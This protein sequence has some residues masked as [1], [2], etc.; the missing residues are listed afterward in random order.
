MASGV[1]KH[2]LLAGY[3]VI[4]LEKP[5][6]SCVRRCVCFA[7]AIYEERVTVEGVTAILVSTVEEAVA[8]TGNLI[9]PLLIDPEAAHLS[10]LA[11]SAVVDGRMLK[12]RSKKNLGAA[13]AVIGLGPGFVVS[14][15]CHAAIET[16]RGTNLGRVLYAGSPQAY[17]GVPA[18]VEGHTGKR[19]VRAPAEGMF[20][21]RC[22]ITDTVRTGQVLG[23]VASVEVIGAI[24][25]VVRGLIHEGS[26]VVLGQKIGDIDP[27]GD[28]ELCHQMS[29]KANVIGHGVLQALRTLNRQ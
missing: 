5:A 1:I 19:V 10:H 15:N 8:T 17:S 27:R 18:S 12:K 7:E 4:A 13:P 21:A 16:N 6:P 11:P 28:R 24:D 26:E 14:D 29:D 20:E 9:V 23:R 22:R 3:E 2:L 25:G